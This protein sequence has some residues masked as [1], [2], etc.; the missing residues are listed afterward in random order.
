MKPAEAA[1]LLT[2]AAAYDNRKPDPDAA[3]AWAIALE[4]YRFED[5]R[6][7]IVSHFRTTSDYLLPVHVIKGVEKIRRARLDAHPLPPVPAGFTDAQE[8]TWRRQMQDRIA[9]GEVFPIPEL[10]AATTPPAAIRALAT[11]WRS[12]R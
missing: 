2:V 12:D 4:G 7:A 3:K 9:D 6:D 5:C 10:P 1:M 11:S 8:L